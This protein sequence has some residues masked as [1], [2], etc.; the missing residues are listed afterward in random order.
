MQQGKVIV[1][2]V[3]VA[4]LVAVASIGFY[5]GLNREI[6]PQGKALSDLKSRIIELKVL[7]EE[8]TLTRDIMLVQLEI[9]ELQLK[10]KAPPVI[11]GEFIPTNKLPPDMK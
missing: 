10:A 7:A 3:V 9:K 8:Q 5:N 2:T 1:V 4:L 11:E 6:T